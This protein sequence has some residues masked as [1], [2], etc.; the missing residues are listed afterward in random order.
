MVVFDEVMGCG[1]TSAIDPLTAYSGWRD[2]EYIVLYSSRTCLYIHIHILK[3]IMCGGFIPICIDS[4]TP[5][6][7]KLSHIC[8]DE[9]NQPVVYFESLQLV[10]GSN[11]DGE[12][13]LTQ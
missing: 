1:A 10:P 11:C 8:V 6:A 13:L 5:S 7:L 4:V 2:N 12:C 3:S 9:Q